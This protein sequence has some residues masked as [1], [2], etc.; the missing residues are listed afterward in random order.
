[1]H[2]IKL[3]K[4]VESDVAAMEAEINAWLAESGVKVVSIVGNIAAQ[5]MRPETLAST[6]GRAY[7]PS[8]LFLAVL[9]EKD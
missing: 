8:D 6:M 2:Q 5:T 3:F 7:A 9:Y 4:S 1:M